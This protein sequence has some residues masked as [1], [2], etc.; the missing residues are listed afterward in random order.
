MFSFICNMFF[1]YY[2]DEYKLSWKADEFELPSLPSSH[3]GKI[4]FEEVRD[5][6]QNV[7]ILTIITGIISIIGGI[8]QIRKKEFKFLRNSS[9][10]IIVMPVLLAIPIAI[11]FNAC[12][13]MFHKIMFSND[14]WIFNPEIDPVINMLPETFFMHMGVAILA[15][16]LICSIVLQ[17]IYR[18]LKTINYDNLK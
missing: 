12:F 18:K 6:F 2:N 10:L 1:S 17:L 5:I 9:I 15:I 8:I 4:H 14:Y 7:K 3:N 11:N 16:M 13:I